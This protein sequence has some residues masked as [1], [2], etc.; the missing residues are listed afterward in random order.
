MTWV[1]GHE[2]GDTGEA[3]QCDI[4]AIGTLAV[5]A[6]PMAEP[7]EGALHEPAPFQNDGAFLIG[8]LLHDA[9][10]HAM[11]V[12]PVL[13]ALSRVNAVEV[14]QAQ[15]GLCLLALIEA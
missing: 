3:A 5:Q 12:A 13:A 11:D 6:A 1:C 15:G 9:A 7:T 14:G 10:R 8:L 2:A 4:E